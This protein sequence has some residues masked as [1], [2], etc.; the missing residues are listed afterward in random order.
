MP[1][2]R[3]VIEDLLTLPALP[4]GEGRLAIRLAEDWLALH[5]NEPFAHHLFAALGRGRMES[6]R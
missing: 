2:A 6:L 5:G 4:P 3:L 1:K